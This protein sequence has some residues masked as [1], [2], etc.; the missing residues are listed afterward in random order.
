MIFKIVPIRRQGGW[1]LTDTHRAEA[2]A[3][4]SFRKGHAMKILLRCDTKEKAEAQLEPCQR[5]YEGLRT[6]TLGKRMGKK[7]LQS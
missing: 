4:A 1:R 7:E 2:W 6:Y 3:V 5:A